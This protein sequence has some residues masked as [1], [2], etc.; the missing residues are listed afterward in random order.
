[1]LISTTFQLCT[2]T[3]NLQSTVEVGPGQEQM[4]KALKK[5]ILALIECPSVLA[6]RWPTPGKFS[7]LQHKRREPYILHVRF[8]SPRLSWTLVVLSGLPPQVMNLN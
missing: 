2:W 5:C 3:T 8:L 6:N 4:A 1:M 7:E